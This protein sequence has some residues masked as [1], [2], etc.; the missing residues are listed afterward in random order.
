MFSPFIQHIEGIN[1]TKI[2]SRRQ[3]QDFKLLQ[4]WLVLESPQNISRLDLSSNTVNGKPWM[5]FQSVSA[6]LAAYAARSVDYD[7]A[8]NTREIA[9][10]DF[11]YRLMKSGV[12]VAVAGGAISYRQLSPTASYSHETLRADI[13]RFNSKFHCVTDGKSITIDESSLD[14]LSV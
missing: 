4:R 5:T 6:S 2:F 13:S 12:E 8:Y 14:L 9:D 7:S 1:L 11:A 10:I 3:I